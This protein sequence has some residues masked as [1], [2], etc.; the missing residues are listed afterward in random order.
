MSKRD[1]VMDAFDPN[2]EAKGKDFDTLVSSVHDLR[3]YYRETNQSDS[4]DMTDEE[5]AEALQS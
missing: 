3:E 4:F 1:E 5:I 2:A